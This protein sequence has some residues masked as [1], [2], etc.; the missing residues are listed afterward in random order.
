MKLI[1]VFFSLK[2]IFFIY[3][4][5]SPFF[6]YFRLYYKINYNDNQISGGIARASDTGSSFAKGGAL[7]GNPFDDSFVDATGLSNGFYI[8]KSNTLVDQNSPISYHNGMKNTSKCVQCCNTEQN[9]NYNW[10]PYTESDWNH[11]YVWRYDPANSS[12]GQFGIGLE[13]IP[14]V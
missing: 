6:V 4:L 12:G 5:S 10:T 7:G 2:N 3:K 9:C 1:L 13:D 11:A 14:G 8:S